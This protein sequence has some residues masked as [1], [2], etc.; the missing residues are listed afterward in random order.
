MWVTDVALQL[1]LIFY[2]VR[3]LYTYPI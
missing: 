2:L 3:K 1:L